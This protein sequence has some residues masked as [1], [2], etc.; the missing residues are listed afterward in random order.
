MDLICKTGDNLISYFFRI[1]GIH[2]NIDLLVGTFLPQRKP[3]NISAKVLKVQLNNIFSSG[4]C[5]PRPM[6]YPIV[7]KTKIL[8]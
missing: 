2:N 8:T 5:R 3:Q 1:A 4:F 6:T 7:K